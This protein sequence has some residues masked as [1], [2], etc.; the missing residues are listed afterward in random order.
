[1]DSVSFNFF[2]RVPKELS[3]SVFSYLM[4]EDLLVCSL[5]SKHF[6]SLSESPDLWRLIARKN[7]ISIIRAENAKAEVSQYCLQFTQLLKTLLPL[8]K[9]LSNRFEQ[10]GVMKSYIETHQ[11][12][13]EWKQDIQSKLNDSLEMASPEMVRMLIQAGGQIKKSPVGKLIQKIIAYS[14]CNSDLH[15]RWRISSRL[16]MTEEEMQDFRRALQVLEIFVKARG[17]IKY[18]KE[19]K[20]LLHIALKYEFYELAKMLFPPYFK[21]IIK[22]NTL[23]EFLHLFIK[24]TES[25][26]PEEVPH[27][28]EIIEMFLRKKVELSAE[29]VQKIQKLGIDMHSEERK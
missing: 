9:N 1:M 19:V 28:K 23:N 22:N 20:L 26:R 18:E 12:N 5:V 17:N 24:R 14:R 25:Y 16:P 29:F 13:E 4:P 21:L 3:L 2:S 27:V 7:N 15:Q 10:Y 11:N 6:K 8:D